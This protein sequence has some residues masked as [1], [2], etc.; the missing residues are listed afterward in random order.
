MLSERLSTKGKV[1]PNAPQNE[2]EYKFCFILSLPFLL[3][4]LK[5]M[6]FQEEGAAAPALRLKCPPLPFPKKRG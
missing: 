2:T 1:R 3:T 6:I 4:F 5:S